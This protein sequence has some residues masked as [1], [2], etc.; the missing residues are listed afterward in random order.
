MGVNGNDENDDVPDMFKE[1]EVIKEE[2]DD[3][4]V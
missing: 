2:E 1:D 4:L 3:D